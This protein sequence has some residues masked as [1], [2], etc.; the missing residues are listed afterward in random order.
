MIDWCFAVRCERSVMGAGWGVI[1][2]KQAFC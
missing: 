2:R 1:C